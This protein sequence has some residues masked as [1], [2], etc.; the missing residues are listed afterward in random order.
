M[1]SPMRYT[2]CVV[3]LLIAG[4]SEPAR[5]APVRTTIPLPDAVSR[6]QQQFRE[7]HSGLQDD[8]PQTLFNQ[9][10]VT[11]GFDRRQLQAMQLPSAYRLVHDRVV[12]LENR[13]LKAQCL[14]SLFHE[15]PQ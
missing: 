13:R 6:L 15:S 1:L 9:D 8:N 5:P 7:F 10:L 14:K 4:C 3:A 11:L 2:L 12:A